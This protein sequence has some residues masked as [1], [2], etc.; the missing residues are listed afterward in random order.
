MVGIADIT[1]LTWVFDLT[2]IQ[3]TGTSSR[4][5]ISLGR[6]AK[7]SSGARLDE[8]VYQIELTLSR[9]QVFGDL[10]PNAYFALWVSRYSQTWMNGGT[11]VTS[12]WHWRS[13]TPFTSVIIDDFISPPGGCTLNMWHNPRADEQVGKPT[14]VIMTCTPKPL[15]TTSWDMGDD[16]ALQEVDLTAIVNQM[17]E[18][19]RR[20]N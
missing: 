2:D 1:P 17:K 15:A 11:K 4:A 12:Y 3:N 16:I 10:A 14:E 19:E 8:G 18:I 7:D 9:R 13:N 6:R 5:P 20:M